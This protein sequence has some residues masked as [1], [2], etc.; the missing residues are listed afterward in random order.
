MTLVADTPD[1]VSWLQQFNIIPGTWYATI[2]LT[3]VCFSIF[4]HWLI[5]SSLL[6][7]GNARN[8]LAYLRFVSIVS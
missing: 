7:A 3:N 2:D 8:A 6:S 1:T 5:K 4:D